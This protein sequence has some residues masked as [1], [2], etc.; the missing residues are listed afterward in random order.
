MLAVQTPAYEDPTGWI[1]LESAFARHVVA[2]RGEVG[3]E[4][5]RIVLVCPRMS[6]QVYGAQRHHM[7]VLRDSD[8]VEILC[9][10]NEDDSSLAFWT[11]S[12]L[13]SLPRLWKQMKRARVLH[14]G[15]AFNIRR[16]LLAL[17]NV[18]AW[19]QNLPTL[20]VLDIDFREDACRYR[21]LGQWSIWKYVLNASALEPFRR[22]QLHLAPLMS[23]LVLFK[24]SSLVADYGRGLPHVHAFYDTVHSA[25]DVLSEAAVQRR[26][27]WLATSESPT[28]MLCYFGRFAWKKGLDRI[29]EAIS[30]ARRSECDIQLLLIGGG[31]LEEA[32][33]TQI[34]SLGLTDCVQVHPQVEYGTRLFELLEAVHACVAA[35]LVEDTP[36]AAFDAFARGLPIVSF[37]T[38]YFR[39]LQQESGAVALASWPD[40]DSLAAA[41]VALA[42]DRG[43]LA[44]MAK[45]AVRFAATNTQDAWLHRRSEWS[46]RYLLDGRDVDDHE[47]RVDCN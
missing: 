32:L 29:V 8:G 42:E 36:R 6:E 34:D 45:N 24:G 19:L 37:D 21:R 20:F 7:T 46:R 13:A 31:D 16:P 26:Q 39:D 18:M 11:R 4:I 33:R 2:L 12:F 44:S 25:N 38:A 43:L 27:D 3:N 47:A 28:F 17:L 23:D 30:I 15:M 35:P 41:I 40:S 10:Y 9:P 5:E 1:A 22:L 14:S